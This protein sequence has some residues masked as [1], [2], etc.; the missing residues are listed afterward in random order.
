MEK[1]Y[2]YKNSWILRFLLK[3][4]G[5][6]AFFR[7]ILV[8][9]A[10]F[11]SGFL[12]CLLDGS[13]VLHNG[14]VGYLQDFATYFYLLSFVICLFLFKK[15]AEK[16][17]FAFQG[18]FDQFNLLN[19]APKIIFFSGTYKDEYYNYIK[20]KADLI[21]LHERVGRRIFLVFQVFIVI[22]FIIVSIFFSLLSKLG[23]GNWN[24]TV[25]QYPFGFFA[26]Q[27]KDFI[28][29][30]LIMPQALWRLTLIAVSTIKICK[31]LEKDRR[32]NI[33]PLD[34]D[35]AGGLKPV[36]QICLLLAYIVLA[37]FINIFPSSLVLGFPLT[38]Q[39]QYPLLFAF[40]I[41]VFFFPMVSAHN[42]MKM[43]KE[44]EL[45]RISKIFKEL[46]M[47]YKQMT[48][49]NTDSTETLEIVNDIISVKGLYKEAE[50]MPVW[51]Y[52]LHLLVKFFSI[53]LIPL[54]VFVIQ[55]FT[56][57]DSIIY[58][59]DKIKLLGELK[60]FFRF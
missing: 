3:G 30:V 54:T 9:S 42:S 52:D 11:I 1:D 7:L 37:Q 58:N 2:L 26:N 31:K 22:I 25:S 32:F 6:D 15:L 12:L 43:A 49:G 53:F 36:G 10:I 48:L 60:N 33:T 46:Y 41:F 14:K 8:F 24:F 51:P 4:R 40:S 19:G 21:G 55:L 23:S 47:R 20:N 34:P 18:G 35:H 39:I 44:N 56:N 17:V 16:F 5:K 13:T 45:Q 38:H 27:M 29:Y 57:V 28:I 59:L 50:E